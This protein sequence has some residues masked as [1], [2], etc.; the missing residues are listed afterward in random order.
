[1][2]KKKKVKKD[3]RC[4]YEVY[5]EHSFVDELGMNLCIHLQIVQRIQ[6]KCFCFHDHPPI[7]F[8]LYFMH[9]LNFVV[10]VF[11]LIITD[12]STGNWTPLIVRMEEAEK[13]YIRHN[14]G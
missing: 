13:R 9:L 3:K 1:M 14:Y 12:V 8:V 11:I 2:G 5:F 4:Q 6:S 7:V 10:M